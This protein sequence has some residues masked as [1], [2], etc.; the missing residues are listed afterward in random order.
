MDISAKILV[1]EDDF[2][3]RRYLEKSLSEIGHEVTISTDNV[4]DAIAGVENTNID[5]ALLDINLGADMET[6][7]EFGDYLR[8]NTNIPFIYL[9]AYST[10]EIV[11]EAIDTNP[12]AYLT[13]PFNKTQLG[14]A[15]KLAT[16]NQE[17]RIA[18]DVITVK[19]ENNFFVHLK[20]EDISFFESQ[21]N[22]FFVHFKNETYRLRSTIKDL[23][24]NLENHNFIQTHRA[25]I[26]NID[27]IDRFNKNVISVEDREI[28]ISKNFQRTVFDKL[29]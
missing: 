28:P 23:L 26:V 25:F 16:A 18:K 5:L 29:S 7:V 3:N 21:K 27:K 19:D 11:K 4:K 9:T 15:I 13:K 6:G 10:E 20:I 17:K 8:N 12:S 1:L 14:I 2:I 24:S 22:Y